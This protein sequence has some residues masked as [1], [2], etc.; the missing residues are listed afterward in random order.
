MRDR[1]Y[2]KWITGFIVLFGLKEFFGGS[3]DD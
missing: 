3:K 2:Y 1:W